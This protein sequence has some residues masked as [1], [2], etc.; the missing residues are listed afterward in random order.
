MWN[1][2]GICICMCVVCIHICNMYTCVICLHACDIYVHVY[3]V[4]CGL[5]AYMYLC[6]VCMCMVYTCCGICVHAWYVLYMFVWCMCGVWNIFFGGDAWGRPF[7]KPCDMWG[8]ISCH[9]FIFCN[10]DRHWGPSFVVLNESEH[11]V[12][13][14]TICFSLPGWLC[15]LAPPSLAGWR[16]VLPSGIWAPCVVGKPVPVA[17]GLHSGHWAFPGVFWRD[18]MKPSVL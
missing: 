1:E 16:A 4:Q 14:F 10:Y 3:D 17:F 18:N 12:Q 2:C 9:C 5:C 13:V 11:C 8:L 15:L 6:G 7:S